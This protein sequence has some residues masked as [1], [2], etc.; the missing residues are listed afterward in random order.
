ML[1]VASVMFNS[2][3][4][5]A[6]KK[7]ASFVNDDDVFQALRDAARRDDAANA[8]ALAA[9]LPNY[10]IP[11]YVDYYRLKPRLRSAS[12]KEVRDFLKRYEGTAIADR[13]RNDWLLEV[14]RKRDW[15]TFDEQYPLFALDDDTQL[16]CYALMSKAAKG[17]NV[18]DDARLVLTSPKD[19]GDGCHALM[20]TLAESGQFSF[21]DV[22]AQIRL[23]AQS[24]STPAA[25]RMAAL[26]DADEKH[27]E[28]A[29]LR[30]TVTLARGPGKTRESH[31]LYVVAL[32]RA[33]RSGLE[34]AAHTLEGTTQI[35][36]PYEQALGW[37]EIALQASLKLAPQTL[38]DYW[39]RAGDVPMSNE[40]YQWRARMALRAGDWKWLKF[41]IEA[42]PSVLRNQPVWIYWL[43][44]AL[45]EEGKVEEAQ[46]LYKSIADQVHFYGQLSLEELGQKITVPQTARPIASDEIDRIA[47]NPGLRRA[48]KFF[49]MNLRFE[50]VREWNWELRKMNERD[51][52][53]AAEFARQNNLI[54]RMVNTSDRT[55]LEV[56]F[57]QRYPSPFRDVMV[58]TTDSL[59]LD[60]AWV[61]GLI[62][63]ESR[64][65]MNAR[66][67]VGASGLM[68]LMPA[69]AH[70][71]ARK[72]GMRNFD[73]SQVNDTNINIALGTNYLNMV[74]RDLDGSQPM[75][76][77]AYNAGPG[78]PRAWRST[79]S[80]PVEGAIFAETIPFDETRGYVKNVLS[81]ATYYAALFEGK[82]QSLKARL[83]TVAPKGFIKSELP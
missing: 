53:V 58:K 66:S 59:G 6:A 29:I 46:K 43:A 27:V 26:T 45:K 23:A 35:L 68:Q 65:I 36:S 39:S 76:T 44:R 22:W 61:Y 20:A 57:N 15:T 78:R 52:L 14:G 82:P 64:F 8:N 17:K 34:Q 55:K 31:Q 51:H 9:R 69:T 50:G 3:L 47:A 10:G 2:P 24:A 63:Q 19:Y 16:K 28:Q 18:V 32:G 73:Q 71:V 30:P 72:I 83:G 48:L 54:D 38:A 21:Y 41:S 77:A 80:R 79:L 5:Y 49:E 67:Y 37:S 81:N 75:A 4:V 12:Y 60:M 42:M 56:D 33:A 13:L 40:A 11:S 74:L 1:V 70:F 25:R 7:Q 62:R